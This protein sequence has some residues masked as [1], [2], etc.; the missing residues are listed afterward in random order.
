MYPR[1]F[2]STEAFSPKIN[3]MARLVVQTL[4]GS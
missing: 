2:S 4:I 1:P 3:P